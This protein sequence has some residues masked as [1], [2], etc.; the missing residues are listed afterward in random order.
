MRRPLLFGALLLALGLGAALAQPF[1]SFS[2]GT[3]VKGTTG[4]GS[5]IDIPVRQIQNGVGFNS[6]AAGT[7]VASTGDNTQGYL[8]AIGAITT[9]SATLPNPAYS[10][11]KWC[12][13]NGT[14]SAFTTNT[15]VTALTTPQNQTMAATF[16]SQTLAAG[17]SA[18]WLYRQTD[19]VW[20]RIQ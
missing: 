10:G 11:Q 7:T 20:Y 9:W 15:S 6:V 16:A 8:V 4:F 13:T 18:C 14:G 12:I 17:S 5:I 3:T 1:T 2:D 19:R